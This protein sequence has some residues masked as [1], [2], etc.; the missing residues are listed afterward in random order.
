MYKVYSDQVMPEVV[1]GLPL[2]PL[3]IHAVVVLVPLTAIGAVLMVVRPRFSKRF[4][5][6]VVASA[7][8]SVVSAFLAKDSGQTLARTQPVS[9]EHV[10]AGD[11]VPLPILGFAVVLTVFWLFDRGVPGNRRRPLWLTALAVVVA[12]AALACTYL[13]VRAGHTGAL[14]VWG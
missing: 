10:M 7:A 1:W 4:G 2:H 13:V 12:I 5:V 3:V 14:S 6:I 9:G 11:V 8:L